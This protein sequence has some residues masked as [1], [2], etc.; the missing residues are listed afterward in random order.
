MEVNLFSESLP[1]LTSFVD[2]Y[3]DHKDDDSAEHVVDATVDLFDQAYDRLINGVEL[4]GTALPFSKCIDS[5]FRFEEGG[6]TIWG[7]VNGNG[8]SLVMGMCALF[9]A[10][11][12]PVCI[13]S[14]EMPP[15]TTIERMLRQAA[16]SR[17]PTKQ[18]VEGVKS[19]LK[20]KLFIYDRVGT[21]DKKAILGAIH[22]SARERGVKHFMVDSLVK[23]GMRSDDYNSQ[24]EFID[25]LQQAAKQ[26][27]IHIHIVHHMRK[28]QNETD[29]PDKTDIKG[30]GEIVDLTDNLIIVNRNTIKQK[31][32]REG[33]AKFD[34]SQPDGYIRI[35]KD[36]HGGCEDTFAFWWHEESHQWTER[37]GKPMYWPDYERHLKV[38]R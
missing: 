29:V 27:K 6:I 10:E 9:W 21:V 18:Y 35:A 37:Q 7:G 8:K 14:M 11:T 15:V 16:M 1:D 28:G 34:D 3:Q 23:C 12:E 13:A 30:A 32:E 2:Y 38:A 31:L 17:Q 24:K 19:I 36:R 33:S 25:E 26:L 5:T 20:D 22:Y 4:S